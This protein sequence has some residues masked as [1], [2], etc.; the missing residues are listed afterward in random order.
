[1]DFAYQPCRPDAEGSP[2]AGGAGDVVGRYARSFHSMEG[3]GTTAAVRTAFAAGWA[4]AHARGIVRSRSWLST[5]R[6]LWAYL[7]EDEVARGSQLRRVIQ[8][9]GHV[10]AGPILDALSM[11]RRA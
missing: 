3:L 7:R 9:G 1:M 2:S 6:R 8:A 10:A 5:M 11:A 4:R